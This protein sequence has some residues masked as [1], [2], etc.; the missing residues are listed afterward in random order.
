MPATIV[1]GNWKMNTTLDEARD[2]AT[3][4][5]TRAE[6][7]AE[8]E[9]VLCPPFLSLPAVGETVSGSAVKTGAQNMHHEDSGAF[10]GEISPLMLAGLCEYVI[11]GH[12]E[13]R[14]LFGETDAAVNLKVKAALTHGLKPI[15]CVGETLEE[16]Q[17][18]KADEV[19]AGQALAGLEGTSEFDISGLVVAYEP[20]WAIGTGQAATPEIAAEIMGGAILGSL[21]TLFG[22]AANEVPLLYGG[23][24]NPGNI[25]EFAAQSCIHGA[26]VGGASLQPDSFVDI[27][28]LAAETKSSA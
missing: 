18:G 14:H 28:R 2:L 22:A 24:V 20:V 7:L 21:Q 19:I 11:L 9:V 3:G 8:V 12:S 10:T 26:L 1:A 6:G 15:I 17:S 25:S 13:R 4:V 27:A 5:K 23:S 16:R